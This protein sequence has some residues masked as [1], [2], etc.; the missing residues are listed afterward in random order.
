MTRFKRRVRSSVTN[1][2]EN[3]T[4]WSRKRSR[5][6]VQSTDIVMFILFL[7][8]KW[9]LNTPLV[10]LLQQQFTPRVSNINRIADG[11]SF[12]MAII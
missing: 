4:K 12:A 5:S 2:V 6:M 9:C 8:G 3:T 11:G 10:A 1:Q 7:S